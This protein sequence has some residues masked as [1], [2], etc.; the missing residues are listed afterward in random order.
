MSRPLRIEFSGAL[1]HITSRGDGREDIYLGDW[2]RGSVKGV[3]QGG[4][5]LPF[6]YSELGFGYVSTIAN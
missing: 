6:A 2:S 4:Q 1:Y 5:V 3:G